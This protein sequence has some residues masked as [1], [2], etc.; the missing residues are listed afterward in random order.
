MVPV[1]FVRF[2]SSV[3]IP[4]D[5]KPKTG[6]PLKRLTNIERNSRVSLLLDSYSDDWSS[7]WWVRLDGQAS[8]ESTN[9]IIHEALEIKYSQYRTISKGDRCILIAPTQVT[10]WCASNRAPWISDNPG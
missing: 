9:E 2:K 4:I 6:R 10:K 5:G 8:I 3:A 7:L 1:V